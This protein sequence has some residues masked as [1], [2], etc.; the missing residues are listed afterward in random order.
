MYRFFFIAKNNIKKQ[1]SDMITFFILSV[2]SSLFIFISASFLADTGK[3]IDTNME[4]I[5]AADIFIITGY[6]E[7]AIAKMEEIIKGNVYFKNYEVEEYLDCSTK[8]RLKGNKDWIE[9]PLF[10]SSYEKPQTIQTISMDPSGLSGNDVV[11]PIS[12]STSFSLGSTFQIK[13]GDNVYDLKVCGYNEDN[14][15]SLEL[16]NLQD[17]CI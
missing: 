16:G 12:L 7:P 5:N 10:V 14:L 13:I 8:Y 6:S 17:I 2:L 3:V 15:L 1:K 4:K 9:Y 11:I